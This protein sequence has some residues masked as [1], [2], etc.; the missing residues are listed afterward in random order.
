MR[1]PILHQFM[2]RQTER[3][4][5]VELLRVIAMMM[6]ILHHY[7]LF[8]GFVNQFNLTEIT[9]NTVLIQFFS[10]GGKIGVNIFFLISG[11]FMIEKTMRPEKVWKLIF[12]IFSI[13]IIVFIFLLLIGEDYS[14]K[15]IFA[16]IP[17]LSDV[18]ISFI[19]NYV[20]IYLLSPIINKTLYIISKKEFQYMLIVL[21]CY[22]CLLESLL[23]ERVFQYVAWAFI[24]YCIGAY[25]KMYDVANRFKLHFGCIALAIIVLSW[26]GMLAAD[27]YAMINGK[28]ES[29]LWQNIY[30]DANKITVFLAAIAIFLYFL[31]SNIKHSK[32][33]NYI[34]GV[35][36]WES[37]Y[38]MTMDG[39]C[40]DG[41]GHKL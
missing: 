12:Q 24:M 39:R 21:L 41:Y 22:Y 10:L 2:K 29:K 20:I 25:I 40:A 9:I 31:K 8:G 3:Q 27:Y 11:F 33:I 26:A 6:I 35:L 19:T 13:N 16:I 5:N 18:P 28:S 14:V 17:L 32:L 36:Y 7:C 1:D 15:E 38:S 4:S 30:T 23:F 34:G 37:C